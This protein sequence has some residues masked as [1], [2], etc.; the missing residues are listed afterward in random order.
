MSLGEKIH[1]TSGLVGTE[2]AGVDVCEDVLFWLDFIE[3]GVDKAFG[4]VFGGAV[5]VEYWH[6]VRV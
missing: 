4:D 6:S 5:D 3:E 1:G 2:I